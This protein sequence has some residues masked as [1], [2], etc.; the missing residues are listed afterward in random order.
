MAEIKKR[1]DLLGFQRSLS[2]Q[3]LAI[4]EEDKHQQEID[5]S[6]LDS[7][8]VALDLGNLQAFIPLENLKT[9]AAENRF[10]KT[11]RTK[12]WLTGFNQERGEVYTIYDLEKNNEIDIYRS[13]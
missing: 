1:L 12:S 2:N 4:V 3:F 13:R 6:S 7:L 9:I 8:G 10:E 11:L 5:E